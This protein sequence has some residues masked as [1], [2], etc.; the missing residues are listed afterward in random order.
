MSTSHLC[1]D[2][3]KGK[4]WVDG[5]ASACKYHERRRNAPRVRI[6][7]TE[8]RRIDRAAGVIGEDSGHGFIRDA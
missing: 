6:G 1:F 8:R 7:R 2:H 3:P 5:T 4:R